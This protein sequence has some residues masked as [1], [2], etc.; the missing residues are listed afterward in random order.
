MEKSFI[1]ALTD[2][3]SRAEERYDEARQEAIKNLESEIV[4]HAEWGAAYI[5]HIDNVTSYAMK[6]KTLYEVKHIYEF[7]Q[8]EENKNG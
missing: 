3:I 5:T 7:Y 6:I 4:T 2:E 8:K 1:E